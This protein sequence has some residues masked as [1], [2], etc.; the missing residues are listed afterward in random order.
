MPCNKRTGTAA[1]KA[2]IP[3]LL[4]RS[5]ILAFHGGVIF[6]KILPFRYLWKLLPLKDTRY[7]DFA[8]ERYLQS[9]EIGISVKIFCGEIL[10]VY[11]TQKKRLIF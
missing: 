1:R 11:I 5:Y 2:A 10:L 8:S 6:L 3:V 4:L 9:A 7:G